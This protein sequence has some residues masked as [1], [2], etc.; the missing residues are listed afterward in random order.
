[1]TD[2]PLMSITL[3]DLITEAARARRLASTVRGDPFAAQL[4]RYAADLDDELRWRAEQ[5]ALENPLD[6]RDICS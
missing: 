6:G 3:L 4:E 5:Q 1:M 2:L